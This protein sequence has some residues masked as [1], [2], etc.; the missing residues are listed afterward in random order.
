MYFKP[1]L[2]MSIVNLEKDDVGTKAD[3]ISRKI[4]E[5]KSEF[6]KKLDSKFEECSQSMQQA[7]VLHKKVEILNEKAE[8]VK[9]DILREVCIII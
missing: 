7:E 9:Y 1:A 2:I 5:T 4:E 8:N 6:C 3:Q